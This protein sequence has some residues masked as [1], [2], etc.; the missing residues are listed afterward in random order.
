MKVYL[1]QTFE[2]DYWNNWWETKRVT[3]NQIKAIEWS[4]KPNQDYE[5]IELEDS[6]NFIELKGTLMA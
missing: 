3:A 4:Q 6:D 5:E 2:S 1:L